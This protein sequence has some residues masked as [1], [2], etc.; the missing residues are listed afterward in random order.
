VGSAL[1][2]NFYREKAPSDPRKIASLQRS[3]AIRAALERFW[4]SLREIIRRGFDKSAFNRGEIDSLLETVSANLGPE[5]LATVRSEEEMALT[6][7]ES[8]D[9]PLQT[10]FLDECESGPKSKFTTVSPRQKTK[11]RAEE[12]QSETPARVERADL[13]PE[14][15]EATGAIILVNKRSFDIFALMF[16]CKEESSRSVDWDSFVHAI[17]DAGFTARS[18][19]GSA[20]LFEG[21]PQLGGKI[22][23]HK[24]H[25]IAKIDPVMLRS[26]GKRM[27]KWFGEHRELFASI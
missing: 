22:G 19:V 14:A 4:A 5:Y 2:E 27:A 13:E 21:N 9:T 18:N 6:N 11:T 20:V 10:Q 24:P 26:M 16:P 7:A 1:I 12:A 8:A 15:N 25:P 3:H 17:T 23:F